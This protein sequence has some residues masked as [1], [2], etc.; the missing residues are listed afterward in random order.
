MLDPGTIALITA[1]VEMAAKTAGGAV[2]ASSAKKLSKKR[3]KEFR[4]ETEAGLLKG[5][6]ARKAE[7]ETHR[8]TKGSGEA[9]RKVKSFSDTSDLVRG[10]LNI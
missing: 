4:R 3:Q 7:L 10:A 8:L 1:A 6:I 2:S 5:D 9:K